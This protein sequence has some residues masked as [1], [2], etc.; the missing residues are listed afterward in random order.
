MRLQEVLKEREAEIGTLEKSL[1]EKDVQE[2]AVAPSVVPVPTT[3][4]ETNGDVSPS[5]HLS[6]KTMHN[7]TEI[8][9]G[10]SH[11]RGDSESTGSGSAPD[12][13]LERLNE[14]MR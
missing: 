13:N 9:H 11:M 4:T 10:M 5:T 6:P 1:L 3:T 14:L 8:R 12:E 7:F 2:R